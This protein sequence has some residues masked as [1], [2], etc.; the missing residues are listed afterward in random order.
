MS[1]R[2]VSVPR[3]DA[4]ESGNTSATLR[5]VLY[6]V[7]RD[8]GNLKS[9]GTL[10]FVGA[11][12]FRGRQCLMIIRGYRSMEDLGSKHRIAFYYHRNAVIY[13]RCRI[14]SKTGAAA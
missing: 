8:R 1:Q 10:V 5:Y 2:E 12:A 6:L 9:G 14:R 7:E 4:E 3:F 11:K 13:G